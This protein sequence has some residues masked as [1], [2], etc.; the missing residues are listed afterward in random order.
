MA[1]RLILIVCLPPS[2]SVLRVIAT[3]PKRPVV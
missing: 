3:D 1:N 2:R